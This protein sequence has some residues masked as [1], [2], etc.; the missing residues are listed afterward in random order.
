M[1]ADGDW[2]G[3]ELG[4]ADGDTDGESDGEMDAD[5]DCDGEADGDTEGLSDGDNEALG[6]SEGLSDGDNE[7]ELEGEP[8]ELSVNAT[9]IPAVSPDTASVGLDVSPVE[10]LILNSPRAITAAELFRE[11]IAEIT[12]KLV[13]AVI[14]VVVFT[15]FPNPLKY[16]RDVLER[17]E[18]ET[19]P[20]PVLASVLFATGAVSKTKLLPAATVNLY[21]DEQRSVVESWFMVNTVP[22]AFVPD[23]TNRQTDVHTP[24]FGAP[25]TVLVCSYNFVHVPFPP[26]TDVC[27]FE[28]PSVV[29]TLFETTTKIPMS[30]EVERFLVTVV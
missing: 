2:L 8:V 10:V 28:F 25:P 24:S 9:N 17:P 30:P 27:V 21:I 29:A 22:T 14:C 23:E 5:G 7:G 3:E 19:D 12:V 6:D 11:R 1:D 15:S 4:E 26:V 18:N 13:E 20:N 16:K